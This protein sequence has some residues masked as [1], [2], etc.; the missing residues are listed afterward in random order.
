MVVYQVEMQMSTYH[1]QMNTNH[2]GIQWPLMLLFT[3]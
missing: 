1:C 2:T 3:A